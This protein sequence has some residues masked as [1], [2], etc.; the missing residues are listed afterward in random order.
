[1]KSNFSRDPQ[2]RI[3][4]QYKKKKSALSVE[5]N[6]DKKSIPGSKKKVCII[7]KMSS[8]GKSDR[9]C[10]QYKHR[11][12]EALA[13]ENNPS[14][15]FFFFTTTVLYLSWKRLRAGDKTEQR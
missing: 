13:E 2:E 12:L 4:P 10:A 7:E 14:F 15:F 3:I 8:A 11:N 1:M 9:I 6:R 5:I